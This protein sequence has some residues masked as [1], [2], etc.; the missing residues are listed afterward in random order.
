M[1]QWIS[2]KGMAKKY[3]ISEE[4]IEELTNQQLITHSRFVNTLMID[5]ESFASYMELLKQLEN[6]KAIVERLQQTDKIL[7]TELQA[8]NET[9]AA[10]VVEKE[11][12]PLYPLFIKAMSTL[13]NQGI[14]RD[15]FYALAQGERLATVAQRYSISQQKALLIYNDAII[16]LT[17]SSDHFIV[18]GIERFRRIEMLNG[19]FRLASIGQSKRRKECEETCSQLKKELTKL[20]QAITRLERNKEII[21]NRIQQKEAVIKGLRRELLAIKNNKPISLPIP[22]QHRRGI[23][24]LIADY[25]YAVEVFFHQRFK[26]KRNSSGRKGTNKCNYLI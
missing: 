5:E 10:F 9:G 26:Q 1:A 19:Y 12:F 14:K 7:E 21:L 20:K 15:I 17:Q 4:E 3:Q 25:L 2:A 24:M 11:M 18:N 8:C 13:I 16:M 23:R 22:Y 6:K